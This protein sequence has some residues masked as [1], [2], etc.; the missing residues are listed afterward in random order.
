MPIWS[1]RPTASI[2]ASARSTRMR[3]SRAPTCARTSSP[4]WVRRGRSMP[5]RSS[6]ARPSTA[7]SS[8]IATSTSPAAR[9]GCWRPTRR[10]SR[11]PG[12]DKLDEAAVGEIPRGRV[13]RGA[14]RPQADHQPLALAQLPDHPL[15]ALDPRQ[16]RADRR[17][18]GDR[19]FL[20]R[21]RHQ[22]RDGRRD[23]AVRGLQG[24]R[25]A[26]E[27]E[28]TALGA[29]RDRAAPRGR[30][31]P[32]FRRRVAG[33][34]RARAPLLGHGPDALRVRADDALQGDH[35]RQS[36][37]ARAGVRRRDRQGGG[38]TTCAGR[39]STWMS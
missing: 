2:R 26:S 31:D 9:P 33:L 28:A 25:R 24:D 30:E 29:L 17:R 20:H 3:S 10:P 21:L 13:R 5:S 38:A 16:H 39:A 22:A 34:V 19:A 4:G 7:S 6:S 37:A 14:R 27:C 32:A 8:R 18:Q 1:S 12:L 11:A 36:R 15:R 35:L 23:R